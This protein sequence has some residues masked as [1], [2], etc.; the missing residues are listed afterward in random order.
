VAEEAVL[1]GP[2]SQSKFPDNW[3]NTGNFECFDPEICISRLVG[4]QHQRLTSKF[5]E[6]ENWEL[7]PHK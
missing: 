4:Q 1:I 5:P 7:N 3:E 6:H 2:V